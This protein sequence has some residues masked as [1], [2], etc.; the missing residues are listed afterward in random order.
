MKPSR[1][2]EK[3]EAEH[4]A[5][6]KELSASLG[7]TAPEAIRA[8]RATLHVLRDRLTI[9]H[10]FHVM[11]NLPSFLKLYFIEGWKY[12]LAPVRIRNVRDFN[13]AVNKAIKNLGVIKTKNI[14]AEDIVR[15]VLDALSKYLDEGISKKIASEFPEELVPILNHRAAIISI[16]DDLV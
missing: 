6:I 5:F 2:F 14:S 9:E 3:F 12:H 4:D 16:E 8:L 11:A 7:C 1:H 10:A 13:R 15:K